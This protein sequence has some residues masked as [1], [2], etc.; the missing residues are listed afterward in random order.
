MFLIE[1]Q[2][3]SRSLRAAP[4]EAEPAEVVL[5]GRSLFSGLSGLSALDPAKRRPL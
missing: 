3:I 4:F 1:D 2:R 5:S